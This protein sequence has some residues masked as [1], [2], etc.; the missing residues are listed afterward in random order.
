MRVV[1]SDHGFLPD[2]IATKCA[3]SIRLQ[4]VDFP[5]PCGKCLPC[6]KKRRSDWSLR[7][8]HE[9]LFSDSALFITLTY[10]QSSLPRTKEGYPTLVKKHVQ[11]YIKR[12]RFK[13]V[14]YVSKQLKVPYKQVKNVSKPIR[15]YAVGEYGSKTR[16]PHYHMIL[17][18]YEISNLA[19]ITTQWKNTD[20]KIT[21]GH[22]DV[23]T[24]TG[25]SINYVTKY[26]FKDFFKKD[27]RV[28]PFSLMSKKPIIGHAYLENYGTHHINNET[29]LVADKNGNQRRLPKAYLH[30]L[31][32]NKQDRLE[33]SEK[34]YKLHEQKQ[35]E[36]YKQNITDNYG[37]D[38]LKYIKTKESDLKRHKNSINTKETL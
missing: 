34:L 26:M 17:F 20:T 25:A 6:Q 16:R 9:Y 36:Q 19:P 8:E 21:M 27:K 3:N 38:V 12:L 29:L 5:V 14:Q 4:D 15:Y 7:L 11:D 2:I 13:H 33:L 10:N 23:G 28:R 24:V 31:F 1:D 35:Y 22:V 18:N 30:R 32:T 37:G